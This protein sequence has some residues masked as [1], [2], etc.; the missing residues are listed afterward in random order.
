MFRSTAW[1]GGMSALVLLAG[2]SAEPAGAQVCVEDQ[3]GRVVCGRPVNPNRQEPNRAA[4][5]YQEPAP[6]R[7]YGPPAGRESAAPP[8]R[9]YG[10]P[11]GREFGPE[12]ERDFAPPPRRDA[13][14]VPERDFAPPPGRESGPPPPL[15][16]DPGRDPRNL[17]RLYPNDEPRY[18]PPIAGP[19]GQLLCPRDFSIQDGLCKPYIRR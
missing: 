9:D 13:R 7:Y 2:L 11:P 18:Q 17:G 5:R 14:P 1:L 10:A 8:P 6:E 15:E 4:P 16:R 3:Y 19:N 12:P